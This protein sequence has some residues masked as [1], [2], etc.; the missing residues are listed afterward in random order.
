MSV[1]LARVREYN[2]WRRGEGELC[3]SPRDIGEAIDLVCRAAEESIA[4]Q[5][6]VNDFVC[7]YWHEIH[8][9]R[10]AYTTSINP[11]LLERARALY[12]PNK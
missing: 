8:T 6:T 12:R 7:S 3:P 1:A 10:L 4:L 2:A 5:D 11:E 9:G